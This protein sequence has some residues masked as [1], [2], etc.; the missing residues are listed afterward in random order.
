[1]HTTKSKKKRKKHAQVQGE[2]NYCKTPCSVDFE[3]DQQFADDISWL[4]TSKSQIH[5]VEKA[6]PKALEERNLFVNKSKTEFYTISRNSSD[7]WK[8]CK[9]VGSK[10]DSKEDIKHR[11]SLAH[12]AF[13]KW[14]SVL[15]NRK[16]SNN[17]KVRLFSAFVVHFSVFFFITVNF[18]VLQKKMKK[19]SM[20]CKEISC[21][22]CSIIVTQKQE[23][24]GLVI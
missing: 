21:E 18:G 9:L 15:C 16:T 7:D 14:A 4:T 23:K 24:I 5:H 12:S 19:K 20:Y 8:K 11:K 10:L 17:F 3:V 2:H 13:N 6:V 22:K 1:M